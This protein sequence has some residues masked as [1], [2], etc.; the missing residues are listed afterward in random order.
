MPLHVH[1]PQDG[2]P[3]MARVR[4]RDGQRAGYGEATGITRLVMTGEAP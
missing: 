1:P 2:K 3:A 4:V